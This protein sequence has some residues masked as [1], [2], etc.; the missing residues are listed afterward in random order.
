[1]EFCE[2]FDK[3][4]NFFRHFFFNGNVFLNNKNYSQ[5]MNFQFFCVF[6]FF[7]IGYFP[8]FLRINRP[9]FIFSGDE[10]KNFIVLHLKNK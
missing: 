6:S 7:G 9:L 1:M 3:S 4:N 10:D 2:I 5:K 8:D